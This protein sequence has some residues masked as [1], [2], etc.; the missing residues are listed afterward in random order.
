MCWLFGPE[1]TVED[2][3]ADGDQ[4]PDQA[5][6]LNHSGRFGTG[7]PQAGRHYRVRR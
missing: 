4:A 7:L 2:Q 6:E 5:V 1:P 3:Q